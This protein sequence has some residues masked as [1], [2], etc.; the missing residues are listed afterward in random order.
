LYDGPLF[1]ILRKQKPNKIFI[2][3]LSAKYGLVPASAVIRNYDLQIENRRW[4]EEQLAAQW[5]AFRMFL[6]EKVYVLMS[7]RYIV[8]FSNA[9][10]PTREE[11][12]IR[13]APPKTPIGKMGKILK[14]FCLEHRR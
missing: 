7:Q 8:P 4:S 6:Y 3:I 11:Q 2:Y 5:Q 14:E 10:A 12:I 13:L 9:I 1:R